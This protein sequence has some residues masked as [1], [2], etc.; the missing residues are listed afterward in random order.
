MSSSALLTSPA[1]AGG[2]AKK[3]TGTKPAWADW[4]G[5][6]RQFAL[7]G[8]AISIVFVMLIPLPALVLDLLLG[9]LLLRRV[10]VLRL[11]RVVLLLRLLLVLLLLGAAVRSLTGGSLLRSPPLV[12]V[13]GILWVPRFGACAPAILSHRSPRAA[14]HPDGPP[15]LLCGDCS[16]ASASA[17][18]LPYRDQI[19]TLTPSPG[20]LPDTRS[21]SS[22]F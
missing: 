22:A 6:A 14:R 9:V 5:N 12:P 11:L 15:L 21:A 19:T 7:P 20:A 17:G 18:T 16:N 13:E 8:G 2:T 1:T 3:S 4:L 10:R